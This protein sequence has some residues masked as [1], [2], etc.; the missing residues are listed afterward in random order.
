VWVCLLASMTIGGGLLRLLDGGPAPRLD[1]LALPA[2]AAAG[3]SQ[4]IEVIYH[5]RQ[6]LDRQRWQAIVIDHSGTP[7][8][9]PASIARQHKAR[10]LSGLGYHFVI[11]NGAGIDD[12]QLHV[13][14]R[15]LDQLPGA[16][17]GGPD[18]DWYNRHAIGICLIGDGD[19]SQFTRAQ[20]TRLAQLVASLM[21]EL[22]IP[23]DRIVLHRSVAPTTAPGALFPEA[24]FRELVALA[25]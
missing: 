6:P 14:Y 15:W 12:G 13:G 16:H 17:T 10:H 8:G 20:I 19:R 4:P 5:T 11:G 22:G 3:G 21:Q 1:G 7:G 18:G 9:T 23:D 25:R 2:L 24:E